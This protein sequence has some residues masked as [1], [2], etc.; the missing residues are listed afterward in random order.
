LEA[1]RVE[2]ETGAEAREAMVWMAGLEA[3]R[4]DAEERADAEEMGERM[5]ERVG[6]VVWEDSEGEG[7][8]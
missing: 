1:G 5:E 6:R 2:V 3:K 4:V 7:S 8:S